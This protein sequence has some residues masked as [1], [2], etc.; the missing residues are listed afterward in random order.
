MGFA[1]NRIAR[2]A[3]LFLVAASFSAPSVQAEASPDS[4]ARADLV[5][6]YDGSQTEIAAGLE[7]R[8]D[9]RFRYALSYG[10]IDEQA[11]GSWTVERGRILLTAAP[12]VPPRFVL[13]SQGDAPAGILSVTLDLP[14]GMSRQY[15]HVES[16]MAEGTTN[17]HQLNDD[18]TPIELQPGERPTAVALLLPMFDLRSEAVPL[19][20]GAGHR[21]AFRFEPNDLGKVA[22][23]RTPL[24]RDRNDLILARYD[25]TIRFR[26]TER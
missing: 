7:L 11:E 23:V 10:A 8:A 21:I 3:A 5:G 24:L 9:G 22:F 14:A 2:F 19:R 13:V 1:N 26:R 25:R 12:V 18:Q 16:R 4:G 20:S 17:D 15:F 6:T